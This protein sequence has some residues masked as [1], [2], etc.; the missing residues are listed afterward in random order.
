MPDDADLI[1]VELDVNHLD[2]SPD[3]TIATESLL[4]TLLSM[5]SQPAVIYLSVFALILCDD[6]LLCI[7]Q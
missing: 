6:N 3:S 1:L 5:P 2:D 4:R 7:G